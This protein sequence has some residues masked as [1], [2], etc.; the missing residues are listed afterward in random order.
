MNTDDPELEESAQF[1][2]LADEPLG[3]GAYGQVFRARRADGNA[4]FAVKDAEIA[5]KVPIWMHGIPRTMFQE[6][7]VMKELRSAHVIPLQAVYVRAQ[8]VCTVMPL[9]TCDLKRVLSRH[10]AL[11]EAHVKRLALS[12][13]EGLA[14]LHSHWFLHRDLSP[15]NVF[16]DRAGNVLLADYGMATSFGTSRK[17]N[18]REEVVTLWYRA[19]ELLLGAEMY[20]DKVDV[21]AFGCILAEIFLGGQPLFN[22]ANREEQLAKIFAVLGTPGSKDNAGTLWPLAYSLI[23]F[24][25]FEHRAPTPLA[26]VFTALDPEAVDLLQQCLALNP[27]ERISASKACA[28]PWFQRAPLPC[29]KAQLAFPGL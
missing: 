27:A 16:V 4:E 20:Q 29:D 28:H 9:Y 18:Y 1:E 17:F 25:L 19:P 6:V 11:S 23:E 2:K 7:M 5:S 15:A 13:L 24:Q 10:T 8:Q 3:K 14:F 26:S 12:I 21:W 22:G